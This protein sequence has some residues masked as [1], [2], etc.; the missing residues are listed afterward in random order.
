MEDKMG[1]VYSSETSMN[2][3]Q[4]KRSRSPEDLGLRWALWNWSL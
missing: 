2:I 4:S 3:Y 1:T